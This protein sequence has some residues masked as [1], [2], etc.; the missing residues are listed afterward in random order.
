MADLRITVGCKS[1]PVRFCPE[2]SVTRAQMATLSYRSLQWLEDNSVP[3][4]VKDA[5]PGV[6]LTDENDLSR[7]IKQGIVDEYA[8]EHPYWRR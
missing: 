2:G 3:R 6:F 4:I 8:D 1:E 5:N 7:F